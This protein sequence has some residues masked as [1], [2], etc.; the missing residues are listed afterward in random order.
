MAENRPP[1]PR[2]IK[3]FPIFFL[4]GLVLVNFIAIFQRDFFYVGSFLSFLYIVIVPG[5][6]LLP[7]LIKKHLPWM[8]GLAFST[9]LSI[10]M[11]MVV[12]LGV[13]TILPFFGMDQPLTT[14]P[15][16]IAFDALIYLLLSF[17]FIFN[18][19]IPLDAPK[20]NATSWSFI[21]ISFLYPILACLGAISLN[22]GGS[23]I[24]T[25][26]AYG[27]AVVAIPIMIIKK[28]DLDPSVPALTLYMMA[29]SFLL[30]NSMRGWFVTGHDILLEYHVFT[31]V[32]TAHRWSMALYQ[33]P[34]M[35]CLSLTILPVYLQNLLHVG[36][37]Y[38]FKFFFQFLGALGVT[39]IYYISRRYVSDMVAF[40]AGFLYIS[41]PT[42][43]T[44]MAFLNRQGIALVFFGALLFIL[45]DLDH[46]DEWRRHIL[47]F[48][49]AT[50][51]VLSHYSTSYVA[52]A[53]FV[54]A[55]IIN[56]ILRLFIGATWPRWFSR[57]TDKF[58]NKEVHHQRVLLTIPLVIVLLGIIIVWSAVITKTSTSVSNTI[59]QILTGIEHPFINEDHTGV[60]KYS[61][62]QST[63][64]TLQQQFDQLVQAKM[65]QAAASTPA[66]NLFPLSL[67]EQ[68]PTPILAEPTI[69]VTS[70][71][72]TVESSTHVV[73]NTFYTEV[74]QVYADIIQILIGLGILGLLI[75]YS[76]RKNLF[77][78]VPGEYIALSVSGVIIL[79]AQT[80]L[81]SSAVDYGLLRL[82]QQDLMFLALPIVLVLL[83]LCSLLFS[84]SK[85]QLLLCSAILLF[86]FVMLSG[87]VPQLTGG[88]RPP[89]PLNNYGFYYDAYYTHA[90]EVS[91]IDWI[92]ENADPGVPI[93]SDVY[94]TNVRM[95]AYSDI[96]PLAGL[97][98][99]TIQ[100][101]A[102]VYLDYNN[103]KT[104]TVVQDV[105]ANL[106]YYHFP[107]SFLDN[108]KDLIYNNG[109][110]EIYY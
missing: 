3:P 67:T 94:F 107:V 37:T 61:L 39:T 45:L 28:E 27:L 6:L 68:Y 21:G 103:V 38:I 2:P 19:K 30:M 73:L 57:L 85:A 80:L 84:S 10:L 66:S 12:G 9:A 87:L 77:R 35:A 5:L 48:L 96:A 109:G 44:D 31:L 102:Y 106:L 18:K 34:Y 71:G 49:L 8:L 25:M 86:F 26:V 41:F 13:N 42:F 78:H 58:R 22:N 100:K 90:Q 101:N 4:L 70:L 36:G 89:L 79:A 69:P 47:L 108:N 104:Q 43:M 83:S 93:Q 60:D 50:G 76:F 63:Q 11:L 20:L 53:I 51:M 62:V 110:S 64:P 23:N 33:D 82:V 98:P 55:Y 14:I 29:L 105:D 74:K 52:I 59:E 92:A 91:S 7:F 16:L 54:G 65:Q 88:A 24:F 32:N 1:V 17:G 95:L 81:P 72:Q 46:T 56:R 40:L 97:Y 75:G 15:L 99:A